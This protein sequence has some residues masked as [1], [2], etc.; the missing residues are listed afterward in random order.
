M[1]SFEDVTFATILAISTANYS[2]AGRV[3]MLKEFDPRTM[4]YFGKILELPPI[5]ELAVK[6]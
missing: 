4:N 3:D 1:T 5:E 2:R 6:V